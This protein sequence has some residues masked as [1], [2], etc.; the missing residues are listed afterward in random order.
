MDSGAANIPASQMMAMTNHRR[1]RDLLAHEPRE[2]TREVSPP[3]PLALFSE[4][5]DLVAQNLKRLRMWLEGHLAVPNA[6][7]D[8]RVRH[9]GQ[10]IR[11]H[12][13]HSA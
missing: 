13:R 7:V 8:V 9:V 10:Q 12:E 6:G 2:G 3:V 5:V 4:L 1:D 11:E